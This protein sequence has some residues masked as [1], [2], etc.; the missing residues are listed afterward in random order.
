VLSRYESLTGR[1]IARDCGFSAPLPSAPGRSLWLFCDTE[2]TTR[3]GDEIGLPILGTGTAAEGPY[4]PGLPPGVLTEVPTPSS[5]VPSSAPPPGPG[6]AGLAPRPFLTAPADLTLP[7]TG[8]P[9]AGPGVYQARWITGVAREPG[10]SGHL[11]IS[12]V[13]SCVSGSEVFTAEAFGLVG[14]DPVANVLSSPAQVFSTT[15]GEQL[16]PVWTLGSPVFSGGYL[17]LFSSCAPA[18]G[19]GTPG[20]FLT[21]TVATAADWQNGFSYQYWTG[22]G[23]SPSPYSAVPLRAGPPLL[24]WAGDFSATGHGLVLIEQTSVGGDFT[25]WQAAAPPGPWRRIT[26]G[27]VPCGA[28]KRGDPNGLCRAL[29]GHPELST[30][31]ELL[32]SFFDPGA[33]HVEVSA[34][35][36]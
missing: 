16:L 25:I 9:C 3:Q 31:S 24:M 19:C 13:D 5:P 12:Y 11:L 14:Y 15:P 34:F 6:T 4:R 7:A 36:W 1:D 8:L 2:I 23:W 21:R 35:R 33:N 27:R 10:A 32:M 17:Y 20:V 28:G 22:R 29:I 30:R 26:A 18:G